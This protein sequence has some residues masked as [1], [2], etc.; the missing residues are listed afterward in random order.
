[1]QRKFRSPISDAGLIC[2]EELKQPS[3]AVA[4]YTEILKLEPKNKVASARLL[5][6]G[7]ST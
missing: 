4:A 7:V 5:E 2:R 3:V 6:L 1:M